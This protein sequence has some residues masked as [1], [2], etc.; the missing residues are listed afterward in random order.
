MRAWLTAIGVM[1]SL[2]MIGCGG[3]W[4]STARLEGQVAI[5]G[6]PIAQG[7]ITFTPLQPGRGSGA[8]TTIESG[9]YIVQNVPQ[10]RVRV[11]FHAVKETGRTVMQFGK[12]YPETVNIIPDKYRAGLEIEVSGDNASQDFRL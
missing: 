8:S 3:R 7:N 2:A 12:P 4:Y 11:D 5:D 10:G 6:R 1:A 9:R